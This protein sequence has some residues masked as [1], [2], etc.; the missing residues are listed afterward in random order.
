MGI[1]GIVIAAVVIYS[2]VKQAVN[3]RRVRAALASPE[4][5][6]RVCGESGLYVVDID[7]QGLFVK[8]IALV[9][10]V[11]TLT[12]QVSVPPGSVTLPPVQVEV[13]DGATYFEWS[14]TQD[15]VM[16]LWTGDTLLVQNGV[17]VPH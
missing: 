12:F 17:A 4:A 9:P 10:G 15:G 8:E 6:A 7:G 1:V 11:H 14:G 13:V 5:T 3:S 16:D 2:S